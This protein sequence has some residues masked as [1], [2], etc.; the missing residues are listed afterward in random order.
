MHRNV[1]ASKLIVSY[2]LRKA[3]KKESSKEKYMYIFIL[4]VCE[5]QSHT[6]G[7]RLY[8]L[9]ACRIVDL[10]VYVSTHR[11]ARLNKRHGR[12]VSHLCTEHPGTDGR[13]KYFKR[14]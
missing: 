11:H 10:E 7:G 13:I 8:L 14:L 3:Y 2:S 5:S 9:A 4:S 12:M 6:H 1:G